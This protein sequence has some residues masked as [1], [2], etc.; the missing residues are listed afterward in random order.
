[1]AK[2]EVFVGREALSDGRLTRSELVRWYQP[3]FRGVYVPKDSAVT[4]WDR[5]KAAWLVTGRQA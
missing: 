5:A 2:R 3:L 1:M 4:L